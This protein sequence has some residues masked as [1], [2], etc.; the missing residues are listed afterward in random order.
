M[1]AQRVHLELPQALPEFF[2]P[3]C[4]APILVADGCGADELC[5]HVRFLIDAE[6][7]IALAEPESF[8]GDDRRRQEEL[9]ALVEET[10]TWDEFLARGAK[11]LRA[12]AVLLE[13]EA[14]AGGDEGTHAVVA[15]DLAP[16][17]LA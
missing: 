7:A 13:L 1:P 8:A 3:A 16:A 12:S 11:I 2:C 9:V 14:H 6:G 5:D 10:E 17:E 4:T 15:L